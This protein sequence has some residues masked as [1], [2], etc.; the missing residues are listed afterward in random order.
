MNDIVA[1]IRE[2][3]EMIL[4]LENEKNN[5]SSQL[6]I[7]DCDISLIYN[8]FIKAKGIQR[9]DTVDQK[10]MFIYVCVS[11]YCPTFIIGDRVK[12]GTINK[13]ARV[14]GMHSSRISHNINNVRFLYKQYK[15][16][17]CEADY[18]YNSIKRSLTS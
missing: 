2:T 6:F 10:K 5:L 18:L 15:D 3:R 13:I 8:L 16:F 7:A 4:S 12:Y 11:L 9:L 1:K 14:T 17:R